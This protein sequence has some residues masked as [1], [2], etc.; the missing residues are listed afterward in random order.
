M[1]IVERYRRWKSADGP[2]PDAP[3]TMGALAWRAPV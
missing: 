2:A 1:S 3:G